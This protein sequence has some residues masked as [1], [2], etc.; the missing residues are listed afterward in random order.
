VGFCFEAGESIMRTYKATYKNTL[1][2]TKQ[3]S[4]WY[5]EFKDHLDKTRR[6]PALTDRKQSEALGRQIEKLVATKVSGEQPGPQLSR[7]LECLSSKMLGYFIKVGLVSKSMS[8]KLL[9][10]HVADFEQS[11][12][13][14]GNTRKHAMETCNKLR[15]FLKDCELVKYSDIQESRVQRYVAS[16]R[17]KPYNLSKATS[18]HSLT[19]IKH[20]CSWM[21]RDR[22]AASSPVA[23][24]SKVKVHD[25][26]RLRTRRSLEVDEVRRLLEVAKTAPA[27]RTGERRY[28][29]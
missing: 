15:R 1:G 9:V 29:L 6:M 24:L 8:G 13:D 10:E 28:Y 7:W 25:V 2:Q 14:K 19:A 23:F 4:K 16:L 12:I 3:S 27:T 18:N 20:F 26:D 22:R 5:V 21:V 17:G 11:L